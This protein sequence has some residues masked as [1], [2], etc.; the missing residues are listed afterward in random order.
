MKMPR[1]ALALVVATALFLALQP[2]HARKLHS[3]K[4]LMD[5]AT[6]L[7][8]PAISEFVDSNCCSNERVEQLL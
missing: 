1:S 7:V 4:S 6:L 8:L 3:S 2:C 5:D